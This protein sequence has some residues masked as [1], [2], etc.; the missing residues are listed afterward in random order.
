[1]FKEACTMTVSYTHL[2]PDQIESEVMQLIQFIDRVYSVFGLSYRIPETNEC[3][4]IFW[5]GGN[6]YD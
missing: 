4:D 1:M 2:R 5:I 6:E 3:Y